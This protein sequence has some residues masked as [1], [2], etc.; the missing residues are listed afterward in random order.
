MSHPPI[1]PAHVAAGSCA[2]LLL[3]CSATSNATGGSGGSGA[4]PCRS[5]CQSADSTCTGP[6]GETDVR[7]DTNTPATS[8]GCSVDY[9]TG[10]GYWGP[11]TLTCG[12]KQL[13]NASACTAVTFQQL[14]NG[15]VSFSFDTTRLGLTQY[16]YPVGTNTCSFTP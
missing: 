11:L 15:Q 5:L 13:C 7:L 1:A 9:G 2:F 10:G 14:Q 12:T 3:A 6:G 4:D 8:G 16:T